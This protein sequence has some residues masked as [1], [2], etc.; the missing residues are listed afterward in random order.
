ML[1]RRSEQGQVLVLSAVAIIVLVGVAALV[2]DLAALRLDHRVDTTAVDFA[3]TSGAYALDPAIGGSPRLGCDKAWGY[4]EENLSDLASGATF[5]CTSFGTSA[6]CASTTSPVSVTSVIGQYTITMETPVPDSDPMMADPSGEGV[7]AAHDGTS[8]QRF[9]VQVNKDQAFL[10][11]PAVGTASGSV[12]VHAVARY[13]LRHGDTFPALAALDPHACPAI[14]AG[15]GFIDA[16]S[17]TDA[18]SGNSSPGI[19]Y[20]DSD[21]AGNGGQPCNTGS[22]VVLVVNGQNGTD[23]TCSSVPNTSSG[24]MWAQCSSTAAG[25]IATYA[26][27]IN[28]PYAYK[29]GY[30]YFPNPT[31]LIQ[32]ITR[33]PVDSIYH[34]SNVSSSNC[35]DDYMN[36][37][38]QAY[39]PISSTALPNQPN[40]TPWNVVSN[41]SPSTG[42]TLQPYTYVNCPNNKKGVGGFTVSGTSVTIDPG[43]PIVFAGSLNVSN[44]GQLWVVASGVTP[45]DTALSDYLNTPDTMLY[46]QGSGSINVT[47][48]STSVILPH[49][50]IYSGADSSG[51]ELGGCLNLGSGSAVTWSAATGNTGASSHYGKL[52]F[53][54]EGYCN[55]NGVATASTFDGGAALDMDGILFSP[56]ANWTITGNSPVNAENVQFWVN[57]ITI[58][59]SNSGLLLRPDP[60][61]AIPVAGGVALIR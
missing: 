16:F 21:G 25:V 26:L 56:N 51:S 14:S 43:G 37:L 33:Q 3:A 9:G 31:P 28:S 40:G 36:D 6:S 4:L 11:A 15:S 61:N 49:T 44:G 17:A 27:T 34:C 47:Q 35:A 18:A 55:V 41:C 29:A 54:S 2:L 39:S 48:S 30:D 5:P 8:C 7:V 32:P 60:N 52:M 10:F 50:F 58:S 19:I 42:L 53:W 13:S 59:S 57:T 20:A 1:R 23:S 38:N 46:L 24:V 22:N 45:G 12:P